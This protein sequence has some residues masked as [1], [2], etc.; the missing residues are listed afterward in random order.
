CTAVDKPPAYPHRRPQPGPLRWQPERASSVIGR[1]YPRVHTHPQIGDSP[2]HHLS[3]SRPLWI[4]SGK[5]VDAWALTARCFLQVAARFPL[6][7]ANPPLSTP[8]STAWKT[9]PSAHD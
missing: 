7:P 9:A 1:P 3:T 8:F 2:V 4:A 6:S 5:R